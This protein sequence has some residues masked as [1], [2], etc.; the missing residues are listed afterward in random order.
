VV[1]RAIGTLFDWLGT[2]LAR[3]REQSPVLPR[4]AA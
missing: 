3:R 2:W 1:K 4:L